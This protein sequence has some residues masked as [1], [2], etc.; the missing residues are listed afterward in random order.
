LT[1]ISLFS[2]APTP[3]PSGHPPSVSW[4]GPVQTQGCCSPPRVPRHM[5]AIQCALVLRRN[6]SSPHLVLDVDYEVCDFRLLAGSS[7]FGSWRQVQ[8]TS[9]QCETHH[10]LLALILCPGLV[11]RCSLQAARCR[12]QKR[13]AHF[14]PQKLFCHNP[15]RRSVNRCNI[16]ASYR[17]AHLTRAALTDNAL[18]LPLA[19]EAFD[20]EQP[21]GLWQHIDDRRCLLNDKRCAST[22]TAFSSTPSRAFR[23]RIPKNESIKPDAPNPA[24]HLT[25]L[26][27]T[28][29]QVGSPG[30]SLACRAWRHWKAWP[31]LRLARCLL[32]AAAPA[33]RHQ[34]LHPVLKQI[35]VNNGTSDTVTRRFSYKLVQKCGGQ[36][37]RGKK[38]TRLEWPGR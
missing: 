4:C 23:R 9:H 14:V 1:N 17:H 19:R 31:S 28:A 30:P 15:F 24:D 13:I 11:Q 35:G 34:M 21:T 20:K 27:W 7:L 3:P 32:I 5:Q 38:S 37:L 12:L 2:S 29:L 10:K 26:Y 18:L 8:R 22:V 33:D 6:T 16:V 25:L 36:H